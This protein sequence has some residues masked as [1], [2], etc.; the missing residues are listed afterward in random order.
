MK[1]FGVKFEGLY[2]NFKGFCMNV[3]VSVKKHQCREVEGGL[4]EEFG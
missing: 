1:Y 3:Q 2:H 4:S